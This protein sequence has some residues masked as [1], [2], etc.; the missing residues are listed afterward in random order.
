MLKS[1][2]KKWKW[3]FAALLTFFVFG[4]VLRSEWKKDHSHEITRFQKHFHDLE[5]E[6]DRRLEENFKAFREEG[7]EDKWI[8][9]THNSDI[10]IHVYRRDSLKYW[11]TN[12]LPILR[13][14]EIH[15]PAEGL[16]HLQ[17]GWY[18]ARI[19][20]VDHLLVCASFLIK[21]DYSYENDD[22]ENKFSPRLKLS[23]DADINLDP[24]DK[25]SY[26][27]VDNKDEYVFSVRPSESQELSETAAV[28]LLMLLLIGIILLVVAIHHFVPK[29]KPWNFIFPVLLVG[30]RYFSIQ[31]NWFEF[32][33][34]V[35]GF[36]PSLYASNEWFPTFFDLLLNIGL[37]SYLLFCINDLLRSQMTKSM[38]SILGILSLVLAVFVWWIIT[39]IIRGSVDHSTIPLVIDE[40]FTLNAYSILTVAAIGVLFYTFIQ[41]LKTIFQELKEA[42]LSPS[43]IVLVLFFI[44]CGYF[45]YD[46]LFGS[47]VIYAAI[48]PLLI[49]GLL[50]FVIFLKGSDINLNSGMVILFLFSMVVSLHFDQV[51][52][53]KETQERRLYANQFATEKSLVAEAEYQNTLKKLK[54]DNFL[55]RYISSPVSL[56]ISDFQE[57]LERRVFNGYWERYE[58]SFA[59]FTMQGEPLIKDIGYTKNELDAIIES[60]GQPSEISP[61]MYFINDYK[62]QYTYV[63]RELLQGRDSTQAILYCT[64]KSKK[65]PEEI[66][67]PRLL[68]SSEANVSEPLEN[69]SIAKYHGGKLITKYGDFDYPT[70][71]AIL[72]L[73]ARSKDGFFLF[74]GY[75][76]Y[77]LQ[78]SDCDYLI[79]SKKEGKFYNLFTAFSY[80]FSFFGL[81]L[82]PV[83]FRSKDTSPTAKVITLALKIQIALVSIVFL[84]LFAFGWGTGSFVST[85]YNE[86]TNTVIS[87]KLTSVE[88]EVKSKLG[89]FE[90]LSLQENGNYMQFILQKFSKVF[91]TDINLYSADGY[92]LATSRP[93]VFNKGLISE[94]MN[95]DAYRNLE[96]GKKSEYVHRER[97]GKLSYSSAYQPLNNYEGRLLGFIN[98]Q[99]FGQ[100][101]EFENQ[102]E[103]FLVAIINVFILLLAVSTVLA[104]F[105]SN[106]LTE[107]LRILQ[108]SFARVKFGEHNQRIHYEK[109]DEIGALVKEYNQKLGELELAAQQVAKNERESAWREMAKQVAHEIKNPLTPMKL[110]VQQLLR[111][112][113][114]ND[115]ASEERLNRVANSMI[116]QIDALTKIANEFSNFAKMPQL[117]NERMNIVPLIDGVCQ[118]FADNGPK[119]TFY[120]YADEVYGD[121][122]KDQFVRVFNN[123]IKN[124]AQAIPT[125]REGRI[126]VRITDHDGMIHI[127][128]E[129]NG[130]GIPNEMQDKI[131]VPYFTTKGTGTGLG[132]AMVKQII[133]NHGGS[134]SFQTKE[135]KGTIFTIV[136]P[137]S[138]K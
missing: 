129:D 29:G 128:V 121:I 75:D 44:G 132:L 63:V 73:D 17:N 65:I 136:L 135:G 47:E 58:L 94:Q 28:S 125:G 27:I 122:D 101:Q 52:N 45:A 40:L 55:S 108:E 76:H 43:A 100:Q 80:L 14:A 88:T 97:I 104:I 1:I 79:L 7:I 42:E 37:L 31:F 134:I 35:K 41:L 91:F 59:I 30:L 54:E 98:L 123:L 131:F 6:L 2:H 107:P 138:K 8:S 32:M 12:E 39:W 89:S 36:D 61:T 119:V 99:H 105:I 53:K 46:L 86:F 81:L 56:S 83:I 74:D 23:F 19:K 51:N 71:V 33:D 34:E 111:S 87:E 67:F 11:S 78:R 13:F 124:A 130:Q 15:F 9:E 50:F 137:R 115:P 127:E 68:I 82:V 116:E 72:G 77:Y 133:E 96:F 49:I 25:E 3:L 16:V 113:D 114:P 69:Y 110:S 48:F 60:S 126:D 112:Y 10:N 26:K 118:L 93:K 66:G 102:M 117:M 20:S 62:G 90:M 4:Y 109:Q 64:L 106:W 38:K 84:S 95:P 21:Q 5:D 85:Q 92:L 24:D 70:Y 22:L 18:Y 57:G 103:R 120:S